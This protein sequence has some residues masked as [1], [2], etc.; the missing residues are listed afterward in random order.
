MAQ[1]FGRGDTWKNDRT[2]EKEERVEIL[3]GREFRTRLLT[4]GSIVFDNAYP[5]YGLCKSGKYRR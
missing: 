4:D 3:M 2:K 1:A 5:E